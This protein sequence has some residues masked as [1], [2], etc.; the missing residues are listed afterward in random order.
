MPRAADTWDRV[1]KLHASMELAE[2]GS[3]TSAAAK[4]SNAAEPDRISK[5]LKFRLIDLTPG[6]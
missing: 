3:D 2:T 1:N 5:P 4:A 6:E